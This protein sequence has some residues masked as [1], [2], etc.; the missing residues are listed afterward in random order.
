MFIDEK[1]ILV[2]ILSLGQG[3]HISL[4]SLHVFVCAFYCKPMPFSV[5]HFKEHNNVVEKFAGNSTNSIVSKKVSERGGN[6]KGKQ[7][8][9]KIIRKLL[10]SL[11]P[12]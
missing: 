4:Y 7:E 5:S 8:K 11:S 10:K 2:V 3:Q 12:A 6:K 1:I 9:E